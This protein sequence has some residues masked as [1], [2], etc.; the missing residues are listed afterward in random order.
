[1]DRRDS[2]PGTQTDALSEWNCE[3]CGSLVLQDLLPSND[4]VVCSLY[5]QVCLDDRPVG[6]ST[7]LGIG[8]EQD[9]IRERQSCNTLRVVMKHPD[10]VGQEHIY[11]FAG[12]PRRHN[13]WQ[14]TRN[15]E[16]GKTHCQKRV[17]PKY[18]HRKT[19]GHLDRF[20]PV[21][22]SRNELGWTVML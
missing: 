6:D 8:L 7:V 20:L 13:L 16:F 12:L 21:P 10:T 14:Q 2:T 1:M 11:P 17:H 4:I 22:I 9:W 18:V 3:V 15:R 19:Q 5:T